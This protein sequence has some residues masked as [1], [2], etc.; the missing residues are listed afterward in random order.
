MKKWNKNFVVLLIIVL[1]VVFLSNTTDRGKCQELYFYSNSV[2]VISVNDKISK[3]YRVIS[4]TYNSS[5]ELEGIYVL[6]EK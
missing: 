3:G 5:K 2:A 1:G 4:I 6:F